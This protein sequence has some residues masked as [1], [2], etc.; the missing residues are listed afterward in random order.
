MVLMFYIRLYLTTVMIGQYTLGQMG[1]TQLVICG[2][3]AID[4]I[5]KF[6]GNYRDLID[7]D[8]LEALSLSVLVDSVEVSEGGTGANIAYN[9]ALLGGQ[10]TLLGSVGPD[11]L[12]YL[13]RLSNMGIETSGVYRSSLPSGSF[14]VLTDS[15]GNQVGGFYPVL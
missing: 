2:S 15:A 1:T 12:D 10:A 4:R 6:S 5:M 13:K 3:I 9:L 7:A 8:K 11:G 14:S